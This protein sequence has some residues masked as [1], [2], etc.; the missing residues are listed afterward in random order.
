M[1]LIP[2]VTPRT[3]YPPRGRR[4][5]V[6]DAVLRVNGE[7]YSASARTAKDARDAVLAD[8]DY[9][10]T[11]GKLESHGCRLY[12]Q[13]RQEWLFVLPSGGAMAYNAEDLTHALA[14]ARGAYA[15]HPDCLAFFEAHPCER[16]NHA[17]C[18]HA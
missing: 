15:E 4:Y 18:L 10:A 12:A 3:I 16:L 1:T 14:K 2:E 9:V 17:A 8:V 7:R 5:R 11:A 6:Y 13:G